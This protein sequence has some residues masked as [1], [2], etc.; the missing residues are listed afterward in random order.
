MS[1]RKLFDKGV[2][3]ADV[4][5]TG[6]QRWYG[7]SKEVAVL[8]RPTSAETFQIFRSPPVRSRGALA[9]QYRAADHGPT[10][11]RAGAVNTTAGSS[12]TLSGGGGPPPKYVFVPCTSIRLHD[13]E[14]Q[15]SR[16]ATRPTCRCAQNVQVAGRGSAFLPA[17][18]PARSAPSDTV[19]CRTAMAWSGCF[20]R[21]GKSRCLASGSDETRPRGLVAAKH[22][23][24]EAG[25]GDESGKRAHD[26]SPVV[27][28]GLL[29]TA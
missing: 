20:S 5:N 26:G 8:T 10:A 24:G 16:S 1:R 4:V 3:V 7:K 15:K 12:R 2:H 11:P 17:R 19:V 21:P 29:L 18:A 25:R 9:R 22:G 13:G 28:I 14:R 27:R 23:D 6:Q